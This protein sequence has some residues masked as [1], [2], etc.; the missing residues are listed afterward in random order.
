MGRN[1]FIKK[2][3]ITCILFQLRY[4]LRL[5]GRL[6]R[7]ELGNFGNFGKEFEIDAQF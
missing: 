3:S 4:A 7:L 6:R 1:A 2:S 5:P